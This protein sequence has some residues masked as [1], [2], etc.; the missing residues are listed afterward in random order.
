MDYS[1][2][3]QIWQQNKTGHSRIQEGWGASTAV[4]P[5]FSEIDDT[6]LKGTV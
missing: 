3:S 6:N 1:T 4:P 5:P 2:G